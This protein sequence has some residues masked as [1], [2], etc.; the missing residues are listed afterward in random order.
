MATNTETI[1]AEARCL[2]AYRKTLKAK[3][4]YEARRAFKAAMPGLDSRENIAAMVC[5]ISRG[6]VLGI[7]PESEASRLL[8]AAQ[9]AL[10]AVKDREQKEEK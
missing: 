7:L 8:Y 10:S 4:E 2:I 3:D 5:C 9:V 1:T 6:M